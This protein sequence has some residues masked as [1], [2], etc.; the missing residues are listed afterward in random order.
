M[1]SR[2]WLD[3]ATLAGIA[4][5]VALLLQPWWPAGF[6]FGFL[7]TAAATLGQIVAAHLPEKRA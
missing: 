4:A 2:A 3:R 6:R 1:N 5:G 7:V